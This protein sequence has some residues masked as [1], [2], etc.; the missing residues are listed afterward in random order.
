MNA[1]A[2]PPMTA[3]QAR[4]SAD[5]WLAQGPAGRAA[6]ADVGPMVDP[7]DPTPRPPSC[8]VT[9]APEPRDPP[10]MSHRVPPASV[11]TVIVAPDALV[12]AMFERATVDARPMG[13]MPPTRYHGR[14]DLRHAPVPLP[15]IPELVPGADAAARR[16]SIDRVAALL[17][18]AAELAGLLATATPEV[19]AR[20]RRALARV[21]GPQ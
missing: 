17:P 13:P 16:A 6:V 15:A 1:T 21:M 2:T 8:G 9:S 3:E 14:P 10:G 11:E 5:E 7:C 19:A 20:A 4:A 18:A 12:V